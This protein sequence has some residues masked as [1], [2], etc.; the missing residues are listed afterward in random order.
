MIDEKYMLSCVSLLLGRTYGSIRAII[1]SNED[2]RG[3]L[4]AL[5]RIESELRRDLHRLY[6]PKPNPASGI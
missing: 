6:Y 1:E 2:M 3:R 4:K 5:D